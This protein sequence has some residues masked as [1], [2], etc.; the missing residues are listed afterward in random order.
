VLLVGETKYQI[1]E[2]TDLSIVNE[3]DSVDCDINTVTIINKT[4][5]SKK[6]TIENQTFV[7]TQDWVLV[8][9]SKAT[10]S[11]V[12]QNELNAGISKKATLPELVSEKDIQSMS[13]DELSVLS[14]DLKPVSL[15]FNCEVTSDH[16]VHI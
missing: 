13:Q 4:P 2:Q 5:K 12:F 11:K 16:N 6:Y 3:V 7:H 1:L 9:R 8:Y 15:N 10:P 14:K